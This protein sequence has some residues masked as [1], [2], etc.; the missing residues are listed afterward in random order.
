[1]VHFTAAEIIT[2][3]IAF[4][5]VIV[6]IAV[7]FTLKKVIKCTSSKKTKRPCKMFFLIIG[8]FFIYRLSWFFIDCF[9]F[10][11][12]FYESII[13]ANFFLLLAGILLY[14]T[15]GKLFEKTKKGVV[16]AF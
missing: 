6:L 9:H 14:Y 5:D 1:M 16:N 11:E 7:L 15:T 2:N 12:T 4:A 8:T 3:I 13:I 10:R